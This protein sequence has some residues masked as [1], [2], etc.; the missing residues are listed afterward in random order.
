MARRGRTT[1][2]D[3]ARVTIRVCP[4][5]I[6]SSEGAESGLEDEDLPRLYHHIEIVSVGGRQSTVDEGGPPV[7]VPLERIGIIAGIAADR[8]AIGKRNDVALE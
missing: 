4:V 6:I 7:G 2:R 3:E 1:R 8:V 5:G